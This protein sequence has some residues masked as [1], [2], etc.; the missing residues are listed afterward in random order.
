MVVGYR[1][2]NTLLQQPLFATDNNRFNT[3]KLNAASVVKSLF[4]VPTSSNIEKRVT[5]LRST[6]NLPVVSKLGSAIKVVPD[7]SSFSVQRVNDLYQQSALVVTGTPTNAREN[8]YYFNLAPG[9]RSNSSIVQGRLFVTGNQPL[10]VNTLNKQL[11]L[12]K[13]DLTNISTGKLAT[14][15]I[16]TNDRARITASLINKFTVR[17]DTVQLFDTPQ[18]NKVS[19]GFV[20]RTDRTTLSAD[21]L[22]KQIVLLKADQSRLAIDKLSTASVLKT[23]NVIIKAEKLDLFKVSFNTTE[24]FETPIS[25][26]INRQIAKLT[27]DQAILSTNK[28]AS[29][30]TVK[31]FSSDLTFSTLEK[32]SLPIG[33]NDTVKYG[34]VDKFTVESFATEVFSIPNSDVLKNGFVVRDLLVDLKN[35]FIANKGLVIRGETTELKPTT[36]V[37]FNTPA[38]KSQIFEEPQLGKL[39]SA[40]VVRQSTETD[41]VGRLSAAVK[42]VG[43][44]TALGTGITD[45]YNDQSVYTTLGPNASSISKLHY[46]NIAPGF[47][48]N[49]S[50]QQGL[51]YTTPASKVNLES[52]ATFNNIGLTTDPYVPTVFTTDPIF[53]VTGKTSN[54]TT[55]SVLW[56]IDDLDILTVTPVGTPTVTLY[57]YARDWLPAPMPAGT[58]IVIRH[59]TGY[60]KTVSVISADAGSVTIVDPGDLP[61]TSGMTIARTGIGYSVTVYFSTRINPPYPINSYITLINNQNN[62]RATEQ[63]IDCGLNYVTYV[64]SI[65]NFW[66]PEF[67]NGTIAS[68][69]VSIIPKSTVSTTTAPT[70]PREYLYYAEL[71]RGYKYGILNTVFGSS[72]SE[73]T[74]KIKPYFLERDFFRLKGL[75]EPDTVR[76]LELQLFKLAPPNKQTLIFEFLDPVKFK[77]F[78]NQVF[79]VDLGGQIVRF[80]TGDFKRGSR[81]IVDVAVPKKE[82][83]QFWN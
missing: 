78:K 33:Y 12:L 68:A 13:T 11:A 14:T 43:E 76:N 72:L 51:L 15:Q 35:S 10:P 30:T 53:S 81:G 20:V 77:D 47:R 22:S 56:Y 40:V 3:L 39:S 62:T 25:N 17:S 28:L 29:S 80:K 27:S 18:V 41:N 5:A 70:T 66:L 83:I 69:S 45:N 65:E 19:Q 44:T 36:M 54:V 7:R 23:D 34:L 26:N 67:D 16:L 73:D 24:V 75:P 64:K 63:V 52:L 48:Y 79:T 58:Q 1:S 74:P 9:Y 31:G 49:S 32:K 57:F 82:P 6:T 42:V 55:N 8:L 37:R 50:I 2:N 4:T 61:S 60:T 59:I 38:S 46:F 21:N 71:A